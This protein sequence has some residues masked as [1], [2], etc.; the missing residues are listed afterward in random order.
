[1]NP[2]S[3]NKFYFILSVTFLSF[4]TFILFSIL[5]K[6]NFSKISNI[7]CLLTGSTILLLPFFRSSAYGG[8][9]ENFGWLFFIL[10][11]F[12][13]NKIKDCFEKNKELKFFNLFFFCFFSSCALYIRPALVFLPISY[14]LYLFLVFKNKETI[15]NSI[16]CYLIFA[17]PGFA[18][19]YLWGFFFD[20][21][22]MKT[23]MFEYHN[24]KFILGNVPILLGY[25]AF[26]FFPIL[27]IEYL[28]VGFKKFLH[29]YIFA[30]LFALMIFAILNQFDILNYLGEFTYGGGA[31]LKLNYVLKSENYILLL[32]FSSIGFAIVY[33]IIK[34]NYKINTSILLPYFVIY[35][36]SLAQFQEYSEP[37]ILLFFYFTII[38]THLHEIYF[39]KAF[40]SNMIVFLYLTTY[41]LGATYYK[42]FM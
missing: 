28:D 33:Q 15:I 14:F 24:Y 35:G 1:M 30:F 9:T 7:D 11:L 2:F 31:I 18:L 32:I 17:I 13:L 22:N 23:N 42:H 34:E 37:L 26:Y 3:Y 36:F 10:S 27:F 5:L 25:I 40:L 20:V 39:R 4:L 6:K 16:I 38:K 41:L 8:T 19:I 21:N 29:K 12:F